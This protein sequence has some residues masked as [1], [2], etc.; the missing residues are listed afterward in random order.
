MM[1]FDSADENFSCSDSSVYGWDSKEALNAVDFTLLELSQRKKANLA[2]YMRSFLREEKS[3]KHVDLM[4][5]STC[6]DVN[7]LRDRMRQVR[8]QLALQ[9]QLID[10]DRDRTTEQ[11]AVRLIKDEHFL[12]S[13]SNTAAA[14]GYSNQSHSRPRI[15]IS[16]PQHFSEKQS[17][18]QKSQGITAWDGSQYMLSLLFSLGDKLLV[19]FCF[20]FLQER[21]QLWTKKKEIAQRMFESK[22]HMLVTESFAGLKVSWLQVSGAC[23]VRIIN[24]TCKTCILCIYVVCIFLLYYYCT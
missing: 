7:S 2:N 15:Q 21:A 16:V 8:F 18:R 22:C 23:A 5:D 24:N 1:D 12:S 17:R 20:L 10:K 14:D 9:K 13:H 4:D 11:A 6:H 19:K 3:R